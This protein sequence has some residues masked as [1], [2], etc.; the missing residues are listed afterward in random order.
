MILLGNLLI[1]LGGILHSVIYFYNL[2]LLGRAICSWVNADPNN[3]FVQ[4]LYATTEPVLVPIRRKV[5]PLGMLDSAF[6]IL[7]LSLYFVDAFVVQSI[8]DYGLRLKMSGY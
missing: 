1:A 5:P 6:L 8:A 2:I 4:F 3:R 7:L